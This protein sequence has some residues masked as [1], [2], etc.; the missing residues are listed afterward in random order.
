MRRDLDAARRRL[1]WFGARRW[2]LALLSGIESALVAFAGVLA[3]WSWGSH[4][5][6]WWREL[7]ARLPAT[8]SAKCVPLAARP[9][10]C[11]RHGA[12]RGGLVWLTVSLK[13]REGARIGTLDLVAD[14][15]AGRH[16]RSLSLAA[17]PTRTS[18]HAG[19]TRRSCSC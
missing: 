15:G 2:Q 4:S 5:P 18:S 13:P 3:G 9:G 14:R 19:V 10:S 16:A 6:R 11:R 12:R 1:T 7:P 8:S 17:S